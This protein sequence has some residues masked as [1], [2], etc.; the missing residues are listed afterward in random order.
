[1]KSIFETYVDEIDYVKFVVLE[2]GR[3]P[4]IQEDR[5]KHTA[6]NAVCEEVTKNFQILGYNG[7]LTDRQAIGKFVCLKEGRRDLVDWVS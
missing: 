4:T 7:D 1:M 6:H 3:F 5:R 2:L